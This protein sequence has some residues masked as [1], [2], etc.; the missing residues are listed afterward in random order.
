M[1]NIQSVSIVDIQAL[2]VEDGCTFIPEKELLM[3]NH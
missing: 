1:Q 3:L 2:W